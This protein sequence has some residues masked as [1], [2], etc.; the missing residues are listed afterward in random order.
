VLRFDRFPAAAPEPPV[1]E[2]AGEGFDFGVE[3]LG[4]L[5]GCFFL[6]RLGAAP[7]SMRAGSVAGRNLDGIQLHRRRAASRRV[8]QVPFWSAA[9]GGFSR[10]ERDGAAAVTSEAREA[11]E[12][13]LTAAARLVSSEAAAARLRWISPNG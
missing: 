11:A 10:F 3:F 5:M 6:C 8:M 12:G 7:S 13:G 1:G 9:C 4:V 2:P